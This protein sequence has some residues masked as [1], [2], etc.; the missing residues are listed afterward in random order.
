MAASCRQRFASA[1]GSP[2]RTSES[3]LIATSWLVPRGGPVPVDDG[4][5]TRPRRGALHDSVENAGFERP[6]PAVVEASDVPVEGSVGAAGSATAS[7]VVAACE[8]AWSDIRAHHPELP[9]VVMV[10]GSGIERGRLVKLGHWWGG[11]WLADGEVRG[12]VLLAGEALHLPADKV[13]EVLLHEAAHGINAARGIKDTSRGGRY[14]NEKFASTAREVLLEVRAMRPYGL[15]A[16]SLSTAAAE[17]YSSTVDRLGYAIRIA[18]QLERGVQIGAEG[19][20]EVEGR[21]GGEGEGKNGSRAKGSLAAECGCGRKLR[22]APSVLARGPV[23][24]GVC[25]SE[26]STGAE[27]EVAPDGE[28]VVDHSFVDRRRAVVQSEATPGVESVVDHSFVDRRQAVVESDR[29]AGRLQ[30]VVGRQRARLAAALNASSSPDHPALTALRDRHQR[31]SHLHERLGAIGPAGGAANNSL[32]SPSDDQ[33][34]AVEH[35]ILDG[36]DDPRLT[37]WYERVGTLHEEPMAA[38]S[39]AEA[40][41]LTVLARSLLQADGTLTGPTADVEGRPFQA[42]D[43]VIAT[44]Q[45]SD[46]PDPGTL[47]TVERADPARGVVYIDFATWG[48]VRADVDSSLARSLDHDYVALADPSSERISEVSLDREL[49]RLGPDVEP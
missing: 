35:L 20:Q 39:E 2:Q 14:H 27:V 12:E 47:G 17:R 44:R 11:R 30:E 1:L 49:D 37:A 15:A 18:R 4:E 28:S 40:G 23:V 7:A 36:G 48:R 10:L 5:T 8:A 33:A 6:L 3:R 13:F 46:G 45:V 34:A 43:R 24:C 41:R 19:D 42:G 38:A 32:D 9:E 31:L 25:G 26:F 22:M 21:L 16:T 29:R